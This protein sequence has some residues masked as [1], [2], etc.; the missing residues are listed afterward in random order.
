MNNILNKDF[1]ETKKKIIDVSLELFSEQGYKGTTIRQ[2]ANAVGIKGSSIYNHFKGKD[3]ILASIFSMYRPRS[4]RRKMLNTEYI[5]E[6]KTNPNCFVSIF[7]TEI[8]NLY[9]DQHWNKVYKLFIMEMFQNKSVEELM[10]QNILEDAKKAFEFFFCELKKNKLIKDMDSDFI[11]NELFSLI[12]FSNI[13]VLL[14]NDNT[15]DYYITLTKK[16]LEY[17]WENIKI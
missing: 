8:L 2:I 13:E 11:A 14:K 7:E 15:P 12:M 5:E 4:F 6:I 10:K 3:E 9:K 1:S 17:L 16:R